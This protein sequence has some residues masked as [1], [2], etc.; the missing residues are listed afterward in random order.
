M[1]AP[2]PQANEVIG[3]ISSGSRRWRE[4]RAA[5]Q[6]DPD[7]QV[8]TQERSDL[9]S[10]YGGRYAARKI[11]QHEN[12][13]QWTHQQ[14]YDALHGAGSAVKISE[15]NAGADGWRRLDE[16][17]RNGGASG[18]RTAVKTFRQ[19]VDNAIEEHWDGKSASSAVNSTR[20]YVGEANKLALTFEL[21]AN[22]IDLL[23]GALGQVAAAVGKPGE[24]SGFDK[25]VE[26]IPNIGSV[27]KSKN[28][29]D[30]DQFAAQQVMK[31]VY[32]PAAREVDD[33]TPI[34]AQAVSTFQSAPK[35][36]PGGKPPG[37]G[38]EGKKP[39]Q[40]PG[41]EPAEKKPIV[42]G[43]DDEQPEDTNLT[44][45]DTT[46][47][48]STPSTNTPTAT[49]PGTPG[50]LSPGAGSPGSGV[51]SSA[52][53]VPGK[54]SPG[55]PGQPT[56]TTAA[57]RGANAS[58]GRNGMPG[59]GGM[60]APGARTNGEDDNE[61]QTPDY[62]VRDHTTELIGEQPWVLPTGGVIE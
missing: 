4:A 61:H 42:D 32:Q 45:T 12:F 43:K 56:T 27:K 2:L 17:G 40:K 16:G 21:M 58:T 37:G 57:A 7:K 3:A 55:A 1:V 59:M 31:S 20:A 23:E 29:A 46:P 36:K 15:I 13:D 34:L 44:G 39:V 38:Q 5:A 50:G 22:C 54:I 26:K 25:A 18:M 53:P 33:R 28:A 51:P 49:T 8:I 24:I 6:F 60:G 30:E 9:T 10:R 35:N 11:P 62:L 48:S 14:I 19:A 47:S 41:G 52:V